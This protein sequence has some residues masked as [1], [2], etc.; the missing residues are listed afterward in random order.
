VSVGGEVTAEQVRW[1]AP[2]VGPPGSEVVGPAMVDLMQRFDR[3]AS[4]MG[5]LL[6]QAE[7]AK[8]D[9]MVEQVVPFQTDAS[10]NAVVMLYQV[11]QGAIG[12]LCLLGIDEAAVTADSPDTRATLSL[13]IYR[14]P[15]GTTMPAT[16][17]GALLDCLPQ[18][19]GVA[20]QIPQ[21]FT[22][23]TTRT[24]PTIKG[25]LAF[26]LSVRNANT[27]RQCSAT[28]SCYVCLPER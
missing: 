13:T 22:Y 5:A 24:S 14:A 10:G 1:D 26:W 20:T 27:S 23:G 18:T 2:H 9:F 15:A 7:H 4:V 12:S 28:F 21:S 17:V 11:P 19:P 25:P 6:R 3:V 16:A 8:Q